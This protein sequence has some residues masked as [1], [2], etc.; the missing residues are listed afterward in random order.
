MAMGRRKFSSH[1]QRLRR[2]TALG[3]ARPP[4]GFSNDAHHNVFRGPSEQVFQNCQIL[5][6][7]IDAGIGV[8][9]EFHRSEVRFSTSPCDGRVK[10]SAT[11]AND[12]AYP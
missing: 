3:C 6:E 7:G 4:F 10:S 8:E 2:R 9:E 5:F 1:P 12:S 11:P